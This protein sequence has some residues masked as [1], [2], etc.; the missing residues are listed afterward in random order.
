MLD[1][2]EAYAREVADEYDIK[3]TGSYNPYKVGISDADFW[4]ARHIQHD[5]LSEF[6]DFMR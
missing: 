1:E 5:K 2:I 6:F 4:D 3:L